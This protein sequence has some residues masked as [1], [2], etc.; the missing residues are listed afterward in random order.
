MG[1]SPYHLPMADDR[2][3]DSESLWA[4]GT[5]YLVLVSLPVITGTIKCVQMTVP[6]S[7]EVQQ[8]M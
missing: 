7:L 6:F 4:T 3:N 8:A 2:L 1:P 5:F